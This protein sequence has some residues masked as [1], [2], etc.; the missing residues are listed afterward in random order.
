MKK[1]LFISNISNKITNFHIPSIIA[2][3]RLGYE[4][5]M[6]ANYSEFKD[7]ASKYNVTIHHIDL[8]RNL[9]SFRNIKA[10]EQMLNLLKE[11]N[12][13]VIHCNTP[14][15]GVL[16]RLCGRMAK[17][18]KI[19]YTVHGFHF[20]KG[21]PLIKS[22]VFKWAEKWMARYT[23]A[24]ITINHEDYQTAQK[25]RLRKSGKVYYIPGVGI[26]T[27]IIK[28]AKPKRE[29]ILYQIG[30]NKDSVLLISVGELNSNKNNKVIINAL[31]KLKNPKIHYLVC[32]IGNKKDE[33]YSLTKKNALDKNVHFLGYRNDIPE[34]LNS[35]DIFIISS[36]RE[37]LPRS[38]ME[39]MA[40]G[41][42]CIASRV[43]GNI[44]L[45]ENGKGGFLLKPDDVDGFAGAINKLACDKDLR[46]SMGII[47]QETV[48]KFDV[49]NVKKEMMRIYE[50]EL[51]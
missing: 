39:A 50:S 29:D 16:G 6:A 1:I 23:D 15:G 20:Y 2:G 49:E 7:D 3:Q 26:D 42:P 38:M 43:R 4:F 27:S 24:I 18:P 31:K 41:L 51:Y 45:I 10:F 33:L 11:Q 19:I 14:I 46:N 34:L 48:K 35:C 28:E 8:V 32:G 5:H 36:F 40:A 12:Y 47:N 21:A 30:A 25:F 17:A 13:D 44:D 9:F 22:T 37:G